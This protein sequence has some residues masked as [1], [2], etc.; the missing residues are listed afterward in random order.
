MEKIIYFYPAIQLKMNNLKYIFLTIFIF[1]GFYTLQSSQKMQKPIGSLSY[2]DLEL[3]IKNLEN[4]PDEQWKYIHHFIQKA[5]KENNFE[6]TRRGYVLA[7][8]STRGNEQITYGDSIVIIAKK[9]NDNNI[10]GDS[11]LSLG[12]SYA[13]NENY[14]KALDAFIKGY[15]YIKK[16]KNPYLI[17]N[18]EYQ[19][20]QTKSYL[21]LYREAHVLLTNCVSFF[22]KHHEKIEDTHYAYYYLYSLISLIETNSHLSNFR[23]NKDLIQEGIEFVKNNPD[24]KEYYAYFISSEGTDLYYQKKYSASVFKLQEAIRLYSDTWKHLTDKF[25]IGMSLWKMEKKE[26]ALPYFL[27]LDH[28]YNETQKLDP[29]FRPAFEMLIRYYSERNDSHKQLEYIDKLI[30]L[31]KAYEKDYKYLNSTLNKEYDT[32]K[33]YEEKEILKDKIMWERFIYFSLIGLFLTLMLVLLFLRRKY[34]IK[35]QY[36]PL[37]NKDFTENQNEK[38][39][40]RN[41]IT[42]SAND[43]SIINDHLGINP[44]IVENVLKIL[45]DFEKEKQF[46]KKNISLAAM[47]KL[48]GTNTVYLSKIINFYKKKSFNEYLNELRLDHIVSQWK[49]KP[50]TRYISIQKTAEN[51]GYN[52]TQT[53]TKNFQEKYHIPPTYFLN[54]LNNEG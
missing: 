12:M 54:R 6:K 20:A 3:A 40:F 33:L 39:I 15:D 4:K 51:A 1:G 21:G 22:R 42:E 23:I 28:E 8:F 26:E 38:P 18:A 5:K 31:D 16:N 43:D 19:I 14:P 25:Y 7:T 44:L 46:L 52:T 35:K 9:I 27:L 30:T 17:H 37:Y 29:K 49:N 24:F 36:L 53:F 10:I 32:K 13:N 45:S 41:E 47:A 50:K 34:F 11:Y 2:S 48:C